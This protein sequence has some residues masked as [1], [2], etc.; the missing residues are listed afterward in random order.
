M[1]MLHGTT[2]MDVT[3]IT[4]FCTTTSLVHVR[5]LSFRYGYVYAALQPPGKG[6][7]LRTHKRQTKMS[8]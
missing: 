5:H 1:M 8:N 2:T 4:F 7:K 6:G 3:E